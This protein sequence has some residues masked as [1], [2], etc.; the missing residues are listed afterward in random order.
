MMKVALQLYYTILDFNDA[1]N[2]LLIDPIVVN[3]LN[4]QILHVNR[5]IIS[6]YI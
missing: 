5:L 3:S 6:R 1:N 2:L 4:G